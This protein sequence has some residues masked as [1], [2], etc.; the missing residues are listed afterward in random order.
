MRYILIISLILIGIFIIYIFNEQTTF[1][2]TDEK[3]QKYSIEFF[4]PITLDNAV[5]FVFPVDLSIKEKKILQRQVSD[6]HIIQSLGV[7]NDRDG[8]NFA[9]PSSQRDDDFLTIKDTAKIKEITLEM[10]AREALVYALNVTRPVYTHICIGYHTK[11]GWQWDGPYG[12]EQ[13][14]IKSGDLYFINAITDVLN[15]N[16]LAVFVDAGGQVNKISYEVR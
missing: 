12:P 5:A 15:V 16:Q 11:S 13:I 14:P 8:V 10:T 2:T 1:E 4:E 3:L 6:E 9:L 7:C